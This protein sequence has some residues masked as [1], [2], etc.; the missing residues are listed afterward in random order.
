[1]NLLI[2]LAL[3]S[4]SAAQ[5]SPVTSLIPAPSHTGCPPNGPL[6]PRPTNLAQSKHIQAATENLTTSLDSAIKGDI[7]AGLSVENVS[8]SLAFTSPSDGDKPLWEYHHVGRANED[9]VKQADGDTQYLIG[10]VSKVFSDL[11]LLKKS[12][13]V[14]LQDPVTKYFPELGKKESAVK[15]ENVTMEALADHLGGIPP[16]GEIFSVSVG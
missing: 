5:F 9:G 10:S 15:W 1:M 3:L 12:D 14:G 2:A 13:A 7:K 16:N 8:F 6:L 4:T 11:L